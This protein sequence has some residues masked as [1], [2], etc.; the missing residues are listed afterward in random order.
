M[1]GP[2]EAARV[3][4]ET[5]DTWMMSLPRRT[6]RQACCAW[7][8]SVNAPNSNGRTVLMIVMRWWLLLV[9]Q[10]HTNDGE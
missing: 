10:V 3:R 1:N 2:G 8:D 6:A 9:Q 7:L 5:I 4:P